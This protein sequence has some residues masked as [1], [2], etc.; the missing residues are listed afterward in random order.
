M[1]A[2]SPRGLPPLPPSAS[3]SR[4]AAVEF[5]ASVEE[6]EDLLR[7]YA[8]HDDGEAGDAVGVHSSKA[9]WRGG[10]VVRRWSDALKE[11]TEAVH[12]GSSSEAPAEE[13]WHWLAGSERLTRCLAFAEHAAMVELTGVLEDSGPEGS[14][15][16]SRWADAVRRLRQ[17]QKEC[18]W[19][20]RYL[21][22][23]ERPL[24]RLSTAEV[25]ESGMLPQ[26]I[27][28]LMRSLNRVYCTSN[29]YRESRM[30]PFLHKVL[31][32]LVNQASEHLV[33]PYAVAR[34]PRGLDVSLRLAGQLRDA[35]ATF[36]DNYFVR[37]AVAPNSAS[38]VQNER[39]PATAPGPKGE[40]SSSSGP[41]RRKDS[42]VDLGWWRATVRC[43][44]EQAEHCQM[45]SERI[46][47]LLAGC[48][49]LAE[50]MPALQHAS[51]RIYQRASNFT[52]LHSGVRN[53]GA[54]SDILDL[55]RRME[56]NGK[57]GE[58]E[59]KLQELLRDIET[60]GASI[61]SK[62]GENGHGCPSPQHS[63]TEQPWHCE[64]SS[65]GVA[66]VLSLSTGGA[67][68][69][70]SLARPATSGEL[71]EDIDSLRDELR[72]FGEQIDTLGEVTRRAT[73]S[74]LNRFAPPPRTSAGIR[75]GFA[76]SQ[77][78][79]ADGMASA[80]EVVKRS[81]WYREPPPLLP[82]G[83]PLIE[84]SSRIQ[85]RAINRVPSRPKTSQPR[86][87][88]TQLPPSSLE[89]QEETAPEDERKLSTKRPATTAC[90][91]S[92]DAQPASCS[93]PPFDETEV[94]VSPTASNPVAV[95]ESEDVADGA[96]G[97]GDDCD[98]FP[99]PVWRIA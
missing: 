12:R 10:A 68:Y 92:I 6:A 94:A 73:A 55:K 27:G 96:S 35:F 93:S 44:L 88:S 38:V 41:S 90:C 33:S 31:K 18:D 79:D 16:A 78:R 40:R 54:M 56:V 52:E 26:T 42:S 47:K 13:V 25:V 14:E 30:A 72:A 81:S 87:F 61:V 80:L 98:P 84:V 36:K 2:P 34:P 50:A 45:L 58:V 62:D 5:P 97:S 69:N 1:Q 32:V 59:E 99:S 53:F 17:V 3:N 37:D 29:F 9:A 46:N 71:Q 23:I 66:E 86:M 8:D 22:V 43:S 60:S 39:R 67:D 51:P 21:Q 20:A 82:A 75:T 89:Q 63:D 57:V 65:G 64:S 49:R 76:E 83:V 28:T 7:E 74:G 11:I 95:V 15:T 24:S 70:G 4:P 48:A 85:M 19:N 77:S 91:L